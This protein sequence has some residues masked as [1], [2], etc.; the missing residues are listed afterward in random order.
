MVS[1]LL[2]IDQEQKQPKMTDSQLRDWLVA[3]NLEMSKEEIPYIS[4]PLKALGRLSEERK[5]S[6]SIPS[7]LADEIFKWFEEHSPADAH[8]IGALFTGAFYFDAYFWKLEIPIAFGVVQLNALDSLRQ[9]PKTVKAQLERDRIMMWRFVE[10]WV[11]SLDY[12]YG[13]DDLGHGSRLP[14]MGNQPFATQLMVSAHRELTA[15]VRLLTETRTPN[16]KALESARMATE[17]YLKAYLAMHA[18]LSE[19]ASK[20]L[21]HNLEKLVA[22]CKSARLNDDITDLSK[23]VSVFPPIGARYQ[24]A[25][26]ENQRLW[27]GYAVALR[28][29]VTFTRSITDRDGRGQIRVSQTVGN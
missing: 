24:G 8:A 29:G 4:R 7:P 23:H 25:E 2:I 26:H 11:D 14:P 28:T 13:I 6:I 15:S 22:A 20:Q 5:I 3:T 19:D 9:M 12:G 21:G 16:A 10:L 1:T 17:M 27:S 18:S